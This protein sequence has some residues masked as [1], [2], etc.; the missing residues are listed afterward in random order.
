MKSNYLL[1]AGLALV[2]FVFLS[3]IS[4]VEKD[5]T[6]SLGIQKPTDAI[7]QQVSKITNIVT[8][9]TDRLNLAVFNKVFADRIISYDIDTQK[10]NH[11]YTLAGKYFFGDSLKDKYADLDIFLINSIID[12]VGDKNHILSDNEKLLLQEK[13]YGIAWYLNN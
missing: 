10:L 3:K 11:L 2:V 5:V 4:G 7:A 12:T 8:N 13:F 6:P 1:I 9:D